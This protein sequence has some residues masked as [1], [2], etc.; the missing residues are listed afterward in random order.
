MM[1]H[2]I[3]EPGRNSENWASD[4][5]INIL[6][7][8]KPDNLFS[9][10]NWICSGFFL[11]EPCAPACG[12]PTVFYNAT[13][14][15]LWLRW[16]VLPAAFLEYKK[17]D[18]YGFRGKEVILK[19]RYAEIAAQIDNCFDGTNSVEFLQ[20]HG[21]KIT[22]QLSQNDGFVV[23]TPCSIH[24]WMSDKGSLEDWQ[25]ELD[26]STISCIDGFWNLSDS[27]WIRLEEL[28]F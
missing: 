3:P 14:C 26:D 21:E 15:L 24:Q 8:N 11:S 16:W 4:E 6:S 19:G 27:A 9:D 17:V 2:F 10:D 1:H 28:Y 18:S 25:D 12:Y 5:G 13:D 22:H 23:Y 20:E 7:P